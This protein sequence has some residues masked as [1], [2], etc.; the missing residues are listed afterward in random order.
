MALV[1]D[2]RYA[3]RTL[4]NSPGYA[5]TCIA[6][7]AL[8]IGA[9]AAIF[10]VVYAVI[11]KPIPFADPSQLVFVWEK[12]PGMPEP[13][14]SRMRVARQN[15]LEWKRQNTVF[16]D[17]AA[18]DEKTLTETG[19][20]RPRH[21]S[22]G[23]ASVNFFPM[24]G[25]KAATGRLFTAVEE[26]KGNDRVAIV[27]D[28]YFERQFH[29]DRSALG[30]S[31]TLG[32]TAYTVVGVLPPKFHLLATYEGFDQKKPEIWLP[33]SRLWSSAADD[34]AR[35]LY[36]TSRLKPG[37][38]LERARTEMTGIAERL[39][40]A[41]PKLNT[42][43][44]AAV[45]PFAVED[46]AP[47]LHRALY[48]LL[49]AVGF[50]LLIACAMAGLLLA[51]WCI[52]LIVALKPEEIQRPELIEINLPVFAF[53]AA[54]SVLTALMFG[55]APA[56]AVSRADLNSA[57]KSGGSWG[58]SAARTR[59]RQFLIA[60]EVAL[61]MVLVTG[62]GLMAR[63]FHELVA[64][65][66]GFET[67][68]LTSIDVDLAGPGYPDGASKARFFRLLMDHARA[69]PGVTAVAVVDNLPLH[70]V[71]FANFYIA[72]RPDPAVNS[73]PMA[74]MARV[75]P[76]Y[77]STIGLRL[78]SGRLF[79]DTDI[80]VTEKDAGAASA[81]VNQAFV[82]K[83]FTGEEALGKRL[84]S[85]DKKTAFEIVGVVTDYRA[86]G[87]EAGARPEIFWPYLK[88]GSATLV[89]RTAGASR[90][91]T[92]AIQNAVSSLDKAL[93]VN[94]V[95]TMD[96]HLNWFQS[97]RKFNTL[98]LLIF[99][100]LA[101]IL[102]M[103]GI[104]GVL[105]NLVASRGKEIGIRM[106]IGATPAEIG[107]LV[108][109]QSMIPVAIGLALGIAGSLALSRFLEALLFQVHPR[110][111]MTMGLAA[112]TILLVSPAAIYVPL[113]RAT[114]IDCTVALRQE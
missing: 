48:I 100:G 87:V 51:S 60:I 80:A 45:F 58:A 90:A 109:R 68:R 83:F 84:L 108:L 53:A 62:A 112:F 101:L 12:F 71:S 106:A 110:D 43:F 69:L 113:R 104:Y 26:R 66:V 65:G 18:F 17:M 34:T 5:L 56:I 50:L 41:D 61:A 10:S 72:G 52:Q 63:S 35:Q 21:V 77:F 59:S 92:T 38:S 25:V 111:P 97:Q 40:K 94:K 20:D 81:I 93:T 86:M 15:Y 22:T 32:G 89:V 98:L 9:N 47:K 99:A 46:T 107:K 8:G 16:A 39:V 85:S 3:L 42:G 49:A 37:V 31:I 7:I 1:R 57:L 78:Q 29:R 6:V 33:M 91:L 36:V 105:A 23:F 75:S 54:A 102:A 30:K 74:D 2:L 11:L 67:A 79:T 14:G 13:F 114:S 19:V 103:M 27:T 28:A 44:T 96:D 95:E 55:L 88:M 73:L 64:T 70:S 24:L 76:G 4:W 82:R